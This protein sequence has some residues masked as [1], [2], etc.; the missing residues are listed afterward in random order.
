MGIVLALLLWLLVEIVVAKGERGT[1][2]GAR[3]DAAGKAYWSVNGEIGPA[4]E[5][6]GGRTGLLLVE[7]EEVPV[8]GNA[9]R[10]RVPGP[11]EEL[12]L[13]VV[14]GEEWRFAAATLRARRLEKRVIALACIVVELW[15]VNCC[16]WCG[17]KIVALSGVRESVVGCDV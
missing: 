15:G 3:C 4:G 12:G 13:V 1:A 5:G 7:V 11:L 9:K 2:G 6:C 16:G 8:G 14:V 17:G 10:W